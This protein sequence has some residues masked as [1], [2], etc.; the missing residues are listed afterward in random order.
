MSTGTGGRPGWTARSSLG[1]QPPSGRPDPTRMRASPSV[2]PA[3][4]GQYRSAVTLHHVSPV[5][6]R[7]FGPRADCRRGSS[8]PGRDNLW[9]KGQTRNSESPGRNLREFYTLNST[10]EVAACRCSRSF[11]LTRPPALVVLSPAAVLTAQP[12]PSNLPP[13]R[14]RPGRYRARRA[15]PGPRRRRSC[16]NYR[17]D[18]RAQVMS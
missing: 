6:V 17:R 18:S 15:G 4:V 5:T 12:G 1:V 10:K 9:P 2:G 16:R 11:C 3:Q 7:T 13:S 14:T 8:G